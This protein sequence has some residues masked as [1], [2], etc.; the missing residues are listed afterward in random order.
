MQ[1]EE[2]RL[3][4]DELKATRDEFKEQSKVFKMDLFEKGFYNLL[5]SLEK[6]ITNFEI[7]EQSL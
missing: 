3:Q 7:K 6:I 1:S 2:L 5:D 4:R